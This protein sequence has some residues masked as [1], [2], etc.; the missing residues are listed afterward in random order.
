MSAIPAED[1]VPAERLAKLQQLGTILSKTDSTAD[2][3]KFVITKLGFDAPSPAQ[4]EAMLKHVTDELEN[5]RPLLAPTEMQSIQVA[6][7]GDES[8]SPAMRALGYEGALLHDSG[9]KGGK[10]LYESLRYAVD[11]YGE[12]PWLGTR[13]VNA[14]GSVGAYAWQTY[15]QVYERIVAVGAGLRQLCELEPQQMV[16]INLKTSAEWTI[17]HQANQARSLVTVTL[18]DTFGDESLQYV[19][20]K[21][22]LKVVLCG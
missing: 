6:G 13:V 20:D 4:L 16:G 14:D 18:Y 10:T 2:E 8:S 1:Q 11:T 12:R 21:C 7:T 15:A 19:V 22:S 5:L 17:A 3:L 9:E